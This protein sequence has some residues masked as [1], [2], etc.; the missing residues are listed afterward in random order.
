M[1]RD[2]ELRWQD[3]LDACGDEKASDCFDE[4][5]RMVALKSSPIWQ[6]L[7]DG[8]GGYTDTLSNPYP[9]F[10]FESG[11]GWESVSR[12]EAE[13]LGLIEPGEEVKPAEFDLASLFSAA[14]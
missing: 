10:A 1:P 6:A 3:A 8:E 13:E 7:G 9:P 11:M 14:A 5:G 2:W 4:T 12:E